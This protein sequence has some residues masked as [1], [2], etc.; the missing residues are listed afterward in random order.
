MSWKLFARM[1]VKLVVSY[2]LYSEVYSY[3]FNMYTIENV[4][5][6]GPIL[7]LLSKKCVQITFVIN[8]RCDV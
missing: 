5:S 1:K 8:V 2:V 3:I 4:K 7:E 6:I